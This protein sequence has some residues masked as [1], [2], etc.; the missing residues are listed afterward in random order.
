MTEAQRLRAEELQRADAQKWETVVACE[1]GAAAGIDDAAAARLAAAVDDAASTAS[2]KRR[3]DVA[4]ARKF[5]ASDPAAA[6]ATSPPSFEDAHAAAMASCDAYDELPECLACGAKL[7]GG[8]CPTCGRKKPGRAVRAST[9]Q[10]RASL[11]LVGLDEPPRSAPKRKTPCAAA[12]EPAAE[13]AADDAA[14]C[15]R[16]AADRL[17]PRR[18]LVP[19]PPRGS[20]SSEIV[21]DPGTL[22]G[23]EAGRSDSRCGCAATSASSTG[24]ASAPASPPRRSGGRGA[25][26]RDFSLPSRSPFFSGVQFDRQRPLSTSGTRQELLQRIAEW[27]TV[28]TTEPPPADDAA[29]DA[30]DEAA[31]SSRIGAAGDEG[32]ASPP[33]SSKR[34]VSPP[35][36]VAAP[37]AAPVADA[38]APFSADAFLKSLSTFVPHVPERLPKTVRERREG[39]EQVLGVPVVA[40]GLTPENWAKLKS[41]SAT[42]TM[43]RACCGRVCRPPCKSNAV[44]PPKAVRPAHDGKEPPRY[45]WF[46]ST[47]DD[48]KEMQAKAAESDPS[49]LRQG[50]RKHNKKVKVNEEV[51]K[52]L[53]EGGVRQCTTC[54]MPIFNPHDSEYAEKMKRI[55][56]MWEGPLPKCSCGAH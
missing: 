32:S 49:T 44:R 27:D 53:S 14:E 56:K 15:R 55:E 13:P 17:R 54:S 31:P 20:A 23:L 42:T 39:K 48:L 3:A 43:R 12:A 33:P 50:T 47:A 18:R 1:F 38:E 11:N 6:E 29:A 45:M 10:Q 30:A 19:R 46:L 52:A 26:A 22:R 16:A 5:S 21:T 8:P 2:A 28:F 9:V 4:L 36:S 7:F 37:V 35:R 41:P 51:Q 40:W 24:S 34:I 25:A